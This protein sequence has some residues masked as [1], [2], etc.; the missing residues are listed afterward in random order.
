MRLGVDE[1]GVTELMAVTEHSRAL[2]T[3][4]AAL[5][6]E[7][8]DDEG[9]LVPA[10]AGAPGDEEVRA[11]LA[12]VGAAVSPAMGWRG[13]PAFWRILARNPHYLRSMWR[14]EQVVMRE[15]ALSARDKRRTA[16]GVAMSVRARYMIE[17]HAA[18]LR[19]AGDGDEA[20]LEI[21]GVVDHYTMLNT[22]SEG[23]QI[24][25]DIVPPDAGR[26]D[27]IDRD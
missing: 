14:K 27:G 22:L 5:L 21:L 18:I 25:S 6:L 2:S 12:E 4:A 15:G 11:L 24:A 7:R 19:Q 1:V 10:L 20:I 13:V 23:M 8:L 9:A 17:Y 26:V 16:L 3:A